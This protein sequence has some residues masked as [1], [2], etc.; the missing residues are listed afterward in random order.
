MIFS[1][2]ISSLL[3][4]LRLFLGAGGSAD[5]QFASSLSKRALIFSQASST[6]AENDHDFDAILATG[7]E[8]DR[9]ALE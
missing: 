2:M 6:L 1:F 8:G 4:Y 7:P 9:R 3:E 5:R